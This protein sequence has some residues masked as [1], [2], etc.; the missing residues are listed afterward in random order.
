MKSLEEL[1]EVREKMQGRIGF[2]R[3]SEAGIR[4]IVGMATSG[5]AGGAR[6]VLSALADA[7]QE[8]AISTV[9]VTQSG[10]VELKG[11]EPVV[12][13]YVP[14]KEKVTYVNMN[15]EK[16]KKVFDCHLKGG[17]VVEE[18]TLEAAEK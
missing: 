14:G 12:E 3:E 6:P 17:E 10:N 7:V 13:V 15:P 18:Y 8:E 5:I 9:N 1:R 16:A 2:R 11:Y 4:V